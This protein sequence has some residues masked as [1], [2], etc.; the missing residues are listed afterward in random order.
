ML[1]VAI[2]SLTQ[3]SYR[4][5]FISWQAWLE[6]FFISSI[7]NGRYQNKKS[8]IFA[9]SSYDQYRYK[10]GTVILMKSFCSTKFFYNSLRS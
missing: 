7:L 4:D 9:D 1:T 2:S 8:M 6:A 3:L 10:E 5:Y